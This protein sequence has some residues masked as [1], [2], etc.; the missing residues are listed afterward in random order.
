MLIASQLSN[1]KLAISQVNKFQK[2]KVKE[3]VGMTHFLSINKF[4]VFF[5][6]ESCQLRH[7]LVATLLEVELEGFEWTIGWSSKEVVDF[8]SCEVIR[9]W[10]ECWF[11]VCV[12]KIL[13]KP[14]P[15]LR[16]ETFT[17]SHKI[18]VYLV[19]FILHL[20]KLSNH[21]DV[22]ICLAGFLA[23]SAKPV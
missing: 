21:L 9:N 23:I 11:F 18:Y 3:N 4:E 8:I 22:N 5:S 14:M 12:D 15:V 16:T 19:D 6:I 13:Q 2:F 10:L 20:Q 7:L 1:F 17:Q